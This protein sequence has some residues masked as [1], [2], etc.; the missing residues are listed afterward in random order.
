MDRTAG[1]KIL[2]GVVISISLALGTAILVAYDVSLLGAL[3]G[4]GVFL[5][6]GTLAGALLLRAAIG[7][8]N[9]MIACHDPEVTVPEPG[10]GKA[11]TITFVATLVNL[12]AG[13]VL[14]VLGGGL[15]GPEEVRAE[16]GGDVI[17]QFLALPV[18]LF[19][20]A[21]LL[22]LLLPTT[23]ARAFWVTMCYLSIALV[24]GGTI[25]AVILLVVP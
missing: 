11:M 17:A 24:I 6:V 1:V 23:F 16:R 25:T 2:L 19:V 13:L 15:A 22:A 14:G 5:V 10:I 3:L 7:A 18:G 20:M 12:F 8:Y 4:M 21:S 9:A